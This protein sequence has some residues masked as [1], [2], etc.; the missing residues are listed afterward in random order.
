M[1]P[2]KVLCYRFLITILGID[3]VQ[4]LTNYNRWLR[5]FMQ[6]TNKKLNISNN[7]ICKKKTYKCKKGVSREEPNTHGTS[8]K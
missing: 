1:K 4:N 7:F 3:R 2:G 5:V 6:L 8:A